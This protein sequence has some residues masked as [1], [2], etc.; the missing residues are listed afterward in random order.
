MSFASLS[1]LAKSDLYVRDRLDPVHPSVPRADPDSSQ[2]NQVPRPRRALYEDDLPPYLTFERADLT[3]REWTRY[4]GRLLSVFE[5]KTIVDE[6]KADVPELKYPWLLTI[7]EVR[8]AIKVKAL[9]PKTYPPQSNPS[10]SVDTA[11][12]TTPTAN[13]SEEDGKGS[14]YDRDVEDEDL[15][16][17]DE[18]AEFER[19]VCSRVNRAHNT[20]SAIVQTRNRDGRDIIIPTPNEYIH[21]VIVVRSLIERHIHEAVQRLQHRVDWSHETV[22]DFV[23]ECHAFCEQVANT[24]FEMKYGLEAEPETKEVKETKECPE[25]VSP[26]YDSPIQI[27]ASNPRFAPF[28]YADTT[29]PEGRKRSFVLKAIPI[30]RSS[31]TTWEFA[32]NTVWEYYCTRFNMK[33]VAESTLDNCTT[34]LG[35][36]R[37]TQYRNFLSMHAEFLAAA[38]KEVQNSF[39]QLV[40]QS[41]EKLDDPI[42]DMRRV[43]AASNAISVLNFGSAGGIL[44]FRFGSVQDWSGIRVPYANLNSAQIMHC[45]LN[46]AD[47]SHATMYQ[48][49]LYG[50]TLHEANLTGLQ[51]RLVARLNGPRGVVDF[52]RDRSLFAVGTEDGIS[53]IESE[54]GQCKLQ[55]S[56]S[57]VIA[58]SFS[59][60]G[61]YL[62][63]GSYSSGVQIWSLSDGKCIHRLKQETTDGYKVFFS[64]DGTMLVTSPVYEHGI[65]LWDMNTK[66]FKTKIPTRT[67]HVVFSQDGRRLAVSRYA[68]VQVYDIASN[69]ATAGLQGQ[70]ATKDLAFS[71]DGTRLFIANLETVQE[72]N[73]STAPAQAGPIFHSAPYPNTIAT[74]P[75]GKLLAVGTISGE[76][77]IYDVATRNCLE[78]LRGHSGNV[79]RLFWGPNGTL[80]SCG[81]EVYLWRITG[82]E[83]CAWTDGLS[84]QHQGMIPTHDGNHII[85]SGDYEVAF[86]DTALRQCRC[87][88]VGNISCRYMSLTRDSRRLAILRERKAM[89]VLELDRLGHVS[90]DVTV[91]HY[92]WSSSVAIS[93]DEQ[94]IAWCTADGVVRIVS[95]ANGAE[96][97]ILRHSTGVTIKGISWNKDGSAIALS[98]N[99]AGPAVVLDVATGRRKSVLSTNATGVY[100]SP[101]GSLLAGKAGRSV[102]IW[103][104]P[105]FSRV[106]AFNDLDGGVMDVAWSHNDEY[107][108]VV[109]DEGVLSIWHVSSGVEMTRVKLRRGYGSRVAWSADGK[110][111]TTFTN[112]SIYVFTVELGPLDV[113]PASN[114]RALSVPQEPQ[115]LPVYL[116]L[117]T[118]L[119]ASH[120][121]DF[122]ADFAGAQA[123]PR[124]LE[125]S[126][127]HILA[128]RSPPSSSCTIA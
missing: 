57:R 64:P 33:L 43:T 15:K 36:A 62:A 6:L 114:P 47:L 102:V 88:L 103:K 5:R 84:S 112:G 104:A 82:Q 51:T 70:E 97:K 71:S 89:Q 20:R 121:L 37:F 127:L 3:F 75:D 39:V 9:I 87:Q 2:Q 126:K 14:Q 66:Q 27:D 44:N 117:Q 24:V 21:L 28:F 86:W 128:P 54:T 119:G 30:Y 105:S 108:A 58:V 38:P 109:T 25:I 41:R 45:N 67:S 118:I 120:G 59:P 22:S 100:F 76:I 80:I 85:L 17:V 113:S 90:I 8:E 115:A 46:G 107:I 79:D 77:Y 92:V 69:Q 4:Q 32:H 52:N 56:C 49:V 26:G 125:L 101:S 106:K 53:I 111:L 7:P 11:S 78:L 122:T 48:A 40:L 98:T 94:Y 23:E 81:N 83:C 1:Q 74:S 50:S 65:Y 29:T 31:E 55:L 63:S 13:V 124:V 93:P 19:F 16:D 91:P 95:A 34:R 99:S 68:G 73:I 35:M 116:K 110:H 123:D 10:A 61:K 60:C 18:H 72:W 42:A 12:T 96:L